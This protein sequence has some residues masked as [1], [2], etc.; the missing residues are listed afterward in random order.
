M[1][2]KLIKSPS[3]EA[4]ED[5]T[6]SNIKSLISKKET[7][8][9]QGT[10]KDQDKDVEEGT[11]S[12][13]ETEK[14]QDKDVEDEEKKSKQADPFKGP[15]TGGKRRRRRRSRKSKRK[16]KKSKRRP[17][18]SKKNNRRRRRRTRRHNN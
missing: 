15:G 3:E 4:N 14:D 10:E 12:V 18:K 16:S 8:S 17:R 1:L 13:Q 2:K 5:T 7:G 6:F 9:V 11:G